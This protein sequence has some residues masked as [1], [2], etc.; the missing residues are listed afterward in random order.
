MI[1][2]LA[3][4]NCRSSA[5][6][7]TMS[8]ASTLT[9]PRSEPPSNSNTIARSNGAFRDDKY[10]ERGDNSYPSSGTLPIQRPLYQQVSLCSQHLFCVVC[11]SLY[12][13]KKNLHVKLT[14]LKQV[15]PVQCVT[16]L[17]LQQEEFRNNVSHQPS[18]NYNRYGVNTTNSDLYSSRS[19]PNGSYR[20]SSYHQERSHTPNYP[21]DNSDYPNLLQN[22]HNF[23]QSQ[24]GLIMVNASILL[25]V[26]LT[27]FKLCCIV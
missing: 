1:C 23:S 7:G 18:P 3:C 25:W 27:E 19:Y 13:C 5:N 9:R 14:S 15:H 22:S 8:V 17:L 20:Q 4:L 6:T 21:D 24:E 26:W 2:H 12:L 10:D 11:F 16:P